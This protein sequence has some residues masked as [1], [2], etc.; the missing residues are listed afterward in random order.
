M[1]ASRTVLHSAGCVCAGVYPPVTDRVSP[2]PWD[3]WQARDKQ[4]HT[5]THTHMQPT[6]GKNNKHTH[7]HRDAHTVQNDTQLHTQRA[8][9]RESHIYTNTRDSLKNYAHTWSNTH[10]Y[11]RRMSDR[12]FRSPPPS[13]QAE[14]RTRAAGSERLRGQTGKWRVHP[15][16]YFNHTPPS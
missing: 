10:A 12:P 6:G 2:A 11:T 7:T 5:H 3:W 15:C 4:P 9:H 14:E 13:S 1:A 8:I 16:E